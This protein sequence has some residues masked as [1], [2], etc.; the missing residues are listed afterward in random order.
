MKRVLTVFMDGL[1]PDSLEHMPFLNSFEHKARIRTELGYSIACHASM[2][3]GV[4]PNKHLLWFVWQYSP[5]TSPF[6][7]AK[8]LSRI[9][10]LNNLPGRY[11]FHK[12]TTLFEKNTAYFGI[13]LVVN[14]P[15][16]YWSCIDVAEKKLWTEP[17]YLENYPTIF[18]ILRSHKI[19]FEIV[20]ISKDV[21][22][23]STIVE[24]HSFSNIKP[25][26]YLFMGDVDH[27]S[28]KI[29]QDSIEAFEKLKRLDAIIK[30]KYREYEKKMGRFHFI[31]FSDHGH[32]KVERRRDMYSVFKERG[33][34]LNNYFHIIDANYAR[35]WFRDAKEEER[36]TTILSELPY[37]F[38]LSDELQKKYNVKM[39]D[40]R[41]GDLVFYLDVPNVF[42]RTIWGFS[43]SVK[44]M[45]GYLPDHKDSD[46][47]FVSNRPVKKACVNLVD[48]LPSHLD[49]FGIE[50]PHYVDG[51]SVWL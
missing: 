37:G 17:Q 15:L 18:D 26:T 43:R 6:K 4:Y 33:E 23:E 1:K 47:V 13:P 35:F 38:I 45:H 5:Q 48:I 27:F 2:Y 25:W 50:T 21:R 32:I 3:S 41:Y 31:V 49:L 24:K 29:G 14:L 20:G 7:W 39:P 51:E 11:F 9:R 10:I 19:E 34:N 28:H 36:V 44:S 40:N 8:L 16:K 46:G 30:K 12:T 22:D 42:S